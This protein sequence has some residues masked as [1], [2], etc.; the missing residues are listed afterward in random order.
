MTASVTIKA[1]PDKD[2]TVEI[3]DLDKAGNLI[4]GRDKKTIRAN[5]E[6]TFHI[7]DNRVIGSV[8]EKK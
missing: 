5:T 3:L 2:V 1:S 4:L 8:K 6:E 7:W